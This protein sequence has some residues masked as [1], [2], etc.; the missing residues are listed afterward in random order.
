MIY[1]HVSRKTICSTSSP[2]DQLSQAVA[3][4]QKLK[5]NV[6]GFSEELRRYNRELKDF[7]YAHMY[8]HHRV[9]RMQV[10][11]EKIL[12]DLFTAYRAEPAG[13][14]SGKPPNEPR[15]G[16]IVAMEI[17]GVNSHIKSVADGY[18]ADG[19]LAIAPALFDRTQGQLL[20]TQPL[21]QI[22]HDPSLW[23]QQV[24]GPGPR[25]HCIQPAGQAGIF[26]GK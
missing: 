19:Y 16:L 10:K 26:I 18:A 21:Q 8:R 1:T 3:D 25:R 17:F 20:N 4:I 11:A 6:I 14:P 5:H 7:L 9:V 24:G 2:L 22:T 13:T 23:H 12:T 15:G